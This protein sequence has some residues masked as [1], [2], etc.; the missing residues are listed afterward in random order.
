MTSDEFTKQ[1]D[2]LVNAARNATEQYQNLNRFAD[3]VKETVLVDFG[4]PMTSEMIHKLAH[5]QPQLFDKIGDFLHQRGKKQEY[6]ATPELTEP[7][8]DLNKA[9]EIVMTGLQDIDTALVSLI[10]ELDAVPSC[11]AL[12]REA[13]NLQMESSASWE[14]LLTAWKMWNTPGMS[15]VSYDRWIHSFFGGD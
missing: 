15:A 10:A 1:F 14:K 7:I 5:L 12:A 6:P 9:F 3:T 2:P 4:M 13:E 8:P 11:K